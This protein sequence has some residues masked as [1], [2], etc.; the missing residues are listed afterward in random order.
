MNN[1]QNYNISQIFDKKICPNCNNQLSEDSSYARSGAF[2]NPSRLDCASCDIHAFND[3]Y[4]EIW[5]THA[6]INLIENTTTTYS[7]AGVLKIDA[8]PST[9]DKASVD[10]FIAIA[11]TFQ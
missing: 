4:L 6:T 10:S 5:Y 1:I 9:F 3:K 11:K 2:I 7:S 8:T